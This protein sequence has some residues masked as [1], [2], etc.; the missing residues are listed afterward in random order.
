MNDVPY[1][2]MAGTA[3]EQRKAA[4]GR[5]GWRGVFPT[6]PCGQCGHG[7]FRWLGDWGMGYRCVNCNQRWQEL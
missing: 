3:A 4:E 2:P 7:I 1:N 5:F 6:A